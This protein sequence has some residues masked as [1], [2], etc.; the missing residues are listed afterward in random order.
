MCHTGQIGVGWRGRCAN[1]HSGG[2][3]PLRLS[4]SFACE[5]V[6]LVLPTA[7]ITNPITTTTTSGLVTMGR[8]GAHGGHGHGHVK[9]PDHL[10][11]SPPSPSPPLRPFAVASSLF[12]AKSGLSLS[13]TALIQETSSGALAVGDKIPG[14]RT[15]A[16]ESPREVNLVLTDRVPGQPS[17]LHCVPTSS[18]TSNRPTRSRPRP[19]VSV[20]STCPPP[21]RPFRLCPTHRRRSMSILHPRR[22]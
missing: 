1:V 13:P 12:S 3:P 6:L 9:L 17:S 18:S 20:R 11:L 21:W 22:V 10:Y 14:F 7:N 16:G 5:H 8:H 19:T 15:S 4:V 2:G